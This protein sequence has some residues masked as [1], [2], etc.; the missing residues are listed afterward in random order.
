[1]HSLIHHGVNAVGLGWTPATRSY[2]AL[3]AYLWASMA[4]LAAWGVYRLD[5]TKRVPW[6]IGTLMFV[7]G[8]GPLLCA[9][10]FAS[11]IAEARGTTATWDKTE[12]TGKV[13]AK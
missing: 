7:V 4:M 1:M 8:Y 3:A 10:N 6:L 9:I 11:Y 5:R 2:L 12:K 13:G